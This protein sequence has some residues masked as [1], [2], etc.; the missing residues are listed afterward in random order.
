MCTIEKASSSFSLDLHTGSRVSHLKTGS[1]HYVSISTF[2]TSN[3]SLTEP[4]RHVHIRLK[5]D[6]QNSKHIVR[7]DDA[8]SAYMGAPYLKSLRCMQDERGYPPFCSNNRRSCNSHQ[9]N[10]LHGY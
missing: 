6:K 4:T 10:L 1:G 2:Y 3:M 5:F 8:F 9:T 7:N